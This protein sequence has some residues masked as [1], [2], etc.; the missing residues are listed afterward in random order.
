MD[1][2]ASGR[3]PA[4][5]NVGLP[6]ALVK[7]GRPL[8]SVTALALVFSGCFALFVSA[9]GQFLPHDIHFLG[10]S[11]DDVGALAEGRVA[12]F[13]FHDRVAFGGSLIAIGCLY[14]WLIEFPLARGRRWAW[15]AIAVSGVVGFASFLSY[16]GYGYLDSWHGVGT[17]ALLPLFATGLVLSRRRLERGKA[18]SNSLYSWGRRAW[19]GRALLLGTGAGMI[20]AG[21]TIMVVGMTSV[22]V[23]QDLEYMRVTTAALDAFNSRL[24]PL[25]AH[26]RAGFGG[27]LTSCGLLVLFCVWY[28]TP[29]RSLAQALACA[30]LFGFGTAI[31]VHFLIGYTDFSHLAPA[32]AG[33]SIYL[34]G[35][36]LSVRSWEQRPVENSP[37]ISTHEG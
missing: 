28:G 11:A 30:G 23:P 21:S 37:E 29:S 33:F 32:Y 14:L 13:M 25:I 5:R 22:F 24:V 9:A 36:G 31:G 4:D 1:R 12:A 27:G 6:T 34:L 19:P 16:L 18:A 2:G 26:D 20:L 7:D 15:R 10:A 35:L 17:A 8:L 3:S